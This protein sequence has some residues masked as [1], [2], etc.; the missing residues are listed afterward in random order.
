M[1]WVAPLQNR[2]VMTERPQRFDPTDG[3][4]RRCMACGKVFISNAAGSKRFC[5]KPQCQRK[6]GFQNSEGKAVRY[7]KAYKVH[8]SHDSNAGDVAEMEA[9]ADK[10]A[11]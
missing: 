9:L 1:N 6:R 5:T 8:S 3:K 2:Q 11:L 10:L 7:R 4:K